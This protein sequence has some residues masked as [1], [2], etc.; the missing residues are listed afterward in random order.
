M[1]ELATELASLVEV[2]EGKTSAQAVVEKNSNI[3]NRLWCKN[4]GAMLRSVAVFFYHRLLPFQA[5]L[6][7]HTQDHLFPIFF[8]HLKTGQ[9]TMSA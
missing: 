7:S 8:I 6:L 5:N 4:G 1:G 3:A 2:P 9:P